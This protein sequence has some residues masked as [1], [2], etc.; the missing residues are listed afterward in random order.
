MNATTKDIT[1]IMGHVEQQRGCWV[2]QL[3]RDKD[4]YGRASLAGRSV[5]VHRATYTL[6]VGAIPAGYHVHHVCEV[7]ACCNPDHLE[8]ITPADHNRLRL[9]THCKHGHEF[10]TEN[11]YVVPG[12]TRRECRLCVASRQRRYQAKKNS[13]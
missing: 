11:T 8:P 12:A 2:W 7:K 1:R 10:T 9:A 6:I 5:G 4:G 3:H 13:S